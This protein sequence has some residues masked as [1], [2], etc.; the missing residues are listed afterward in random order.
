MLSHFARTI[1]I[2][3]PITQQRRHISLILHVLGEPQRD[4]EA[5]PFWIGHARSFYS[6]GG[7]VLREAVLS[8][9]ID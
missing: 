5:L 4:K 9:I 3:F 7:A 6:Q 2:R 8:N 1:P